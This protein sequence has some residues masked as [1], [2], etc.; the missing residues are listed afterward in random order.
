[1]DVTDNDCTASS[2]RS[3][4]QNPRATARSKPSGKPAMQGKASM[5]QVISWYRSIKPSGAMRGG[6]QSRIPIVV[7]VEDSEAFDR[8]VLQKLVFILKTQREVHRLPMMLVMGL[9]SANCE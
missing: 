9:S 1:S 2:N 3:S 4:I 8:V 7:V 5:Q 6:K